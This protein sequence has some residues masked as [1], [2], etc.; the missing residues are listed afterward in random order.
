VAHLVQRAE[1]LGYA[2]AEVISLADRHMND[3]AYGGS[4]AEPLSTDEYWTLVEAASEVEDWLNDNV[5]PEGYSF[6]WHEGEFFLW[7]EKQWEE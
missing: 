4:G 6:G 3:H 1:E 2:D 5:A 7:S